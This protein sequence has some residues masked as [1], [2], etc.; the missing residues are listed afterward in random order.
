MTA[1]AGLRGRRL[2]PGDAVSV[3]APCSPVP[4][5]VLDAGLAVLRGWGLEVVEGEHLRGSHPRLPYL[6]GTDAE[7]AA[8]LQR[9][10]LDPRTSAVVCARGGDGAHRVLDRLDFTELRSA[11]AKVLVGFSDVTALHEA[12]AVEL[13]AATLHGP[14]VGLESF[15]EDAAAAEHLRTTLFAPESATVLTAPG[16]ETLVAGRARGVTVGG[17]LSVLNDSLA[18]PHSRA[19]AAGGLVLLEDVAEDVSRIDRML[20][21]LLRSGWMEGAAGVLL[22]SWA[23]CTPDAATVRTLMLER[24]AP[25]G[26]PVVGE[27]GFG[28]RPAQLTV[29]LGAAAVLDAGARTLALERP[30]LL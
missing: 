5:D 20:T 14:V 7:R 2:H 6:A 10:W 8:D 18:A 4:G 23:R 11:P 13:G 17:N 16:A 22:G 24:L 15:T 29:P 12:F 1:A 19:S 27:F 30:A 3:V 28:H 21:Q 9:A 26:V 25:L